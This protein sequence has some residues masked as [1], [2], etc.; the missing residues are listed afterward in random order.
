MLRP[1]SCCVFVL[2]ISQWPVPCRSIYG[3]ARFVDEDLT[4]KH[5]VGTV[6]MANTGAAGHQ[7]I[8]GALYM[9]GPVRVRPCR[10][11]C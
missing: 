5:A 6:A 7:Q 9:R 10:S 4:L 1:R 3:G 2:R 11:A 8:Q